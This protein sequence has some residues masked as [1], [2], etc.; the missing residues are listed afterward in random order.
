MEK[1]VDYFTT[2]F[3]DLLGK[4]N[5]RNHPAL[6]DRYA[7]YV[8]DHADSLARRYT[9]DRKPTATT[10]CSSVECEREVWYAAHLCEQ[11]N[12]PDWR[13]YHTFE[14][15]YMYECWIKALLVETGAKYGTHTSYQL[16]WELP[17]YGRIYVGPDMTDVY[18]P[19]GDARE[20]LGYT[21]LGGIIGEIKS[22]S[23]ASFD[24]IREKGVYSGKPSY[25]S[26]CQLGIQGAGADVCIL[27]VVC[28]NTGQFVEIW[29]DRDQQHLSDLNALFLRTHTVQL[30]QVARGH[31][32]DPVE[33]YHRGKERPDTTNPL[34]ENRNVNDHLVGWYETTNYCLKWQCS[35]C[36]YRDRC[37]QSTHTLTEDW[38]NNSLTVYATPKE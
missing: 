28:K 12:P 30:D 5:A 23:A 8:A 18:V 13:G 17:E 36:S 20:I 21:P 11:S 4:L 33:F 1:P 34:R 38:E 14:Q 22:A 16:P 35:Y 25:Y 2:K 10:Y 32:L 6:W 3:R 15:G 29:I 26:Q 9:Y 31:V 27:I 24:R 19:D 7:E 37:Y